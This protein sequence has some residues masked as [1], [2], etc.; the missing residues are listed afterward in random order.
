MQK[1]ITKAEAPSGPALSLTTAPITCARYISTILSPAAVSIPLIVLVAFYHTSTL[2]PA[3]GY[4]SL[5]LFFLSFGPL[6]YILL[7]VRLGKL[8]DFD[9][10]RRTERTGPFFFGLLSVTLGLLALLFLHAPRNLETVMMITAAS[11]LVMIGITW[12]WKISI[13]AATLAGAL[14]ML[15]A[16]YGV[17]MLPTFGLLVLVSWSR[18]LL[19]RHTVAQVIAGSLVSVVLTSAVLLL[20][21]W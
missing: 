9:V 8:S 18:V 21:G 2:F 17:G 20:R 3:L 1:H 7:G 14:T 12:R 5:T 19:R 15:T 13:H 11:G 10:S 6:V 4:A 16:L